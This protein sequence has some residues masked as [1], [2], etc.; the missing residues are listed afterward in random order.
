[1]QARNRLRHFDKL[2]LELGPTYNS[3]TLSLGTRIGSLKR[4]KK[5]LMWSVNVL[6]HFLYNESTNKMKVFHGFWE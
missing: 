4:I 2:K 3:G 6:F 1:M 5:T